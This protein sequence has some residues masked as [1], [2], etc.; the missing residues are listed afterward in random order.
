MKMAPC[1]ANE[2]ASASARRAEIQCLQR[3]TISCAAECSL[4][5]QISLRHCRV[6]EENLTFTADMNVT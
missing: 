6:S 5:S 2:K 4:S 3:K 1:Y